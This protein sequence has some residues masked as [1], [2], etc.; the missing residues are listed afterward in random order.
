MGQR[1][2]LV[3]GG[4]RYFGRRLVHDLAARGD[5][6]TVLT[7]GNIA[8]ALPKG[9]E[10]LKADRADPLALR[11]VLKSRQWDLVF[12]QVCFQ[13]ADAQ[14]SVELFTGRVG[15]YV[16]TSTQSVYSADGLQR[17][18]DFDP[19]RHV[20]V[21]H[22]DS[23][24]EG[25]QSAEAVFFQA[26]DLCVVAMRIP[27]VLGP[28]DYTKRLAFHV[29]RALQGRAVVVPNLHAEM[30]LISSA[31]AARALLWL[32][33]SAMVGPINISSP[34][35]ISM[36][37][38]LG[39]IEREVG[40]RPMVQSAGADADTTHLIGSQTRVLDT[41]KAIQLGLT[42]DPYERWLPTLVH[43]LAKQQV[44]LPHGP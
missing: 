12:D 3:I 24:A 14:T 34:G 42:C 19:F 17:E 36:A 41:S 28:D 22:T 16:L 26:S 8:L 23:Y 37:T 6:V 29:E 25:K 35:S 4:T 1:Q 39:W 5:C 15:R 43:E 20:I 10:W 31:D 33:D 32:A 9:V 44:P 40:Q 30:S 11:A 7:R 2:V 21:P 13:G 18:V 38:L 27:I